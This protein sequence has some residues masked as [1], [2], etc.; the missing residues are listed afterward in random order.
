MIE[1]QAELVRNGVEANYVLIA[2]RS[3]GATKTIE[4]IVVKKD[5]GTSRESICYSRSRVEKLRCTGVSLT[6][7]PSAA[8]CGIKG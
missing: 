6:Q 3:A 4:F 8:Q 7:G 1:L 2:E 5:S